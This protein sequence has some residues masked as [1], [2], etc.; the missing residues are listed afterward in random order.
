MATEAQI[1]ANRAN[2]GRSTGPKT[3]AGKAASRRNALVHGLAGEGVVL[4]DEMGRELDDRLAG[5]AEELRPAGRVEAFLVRAAAVESLKYDHATRHRF[6][7]LAHRVRHAEV[8]W[9]AAR[10]AGVEAIVTELDVA[11]TPARSS[12]ACGAPPRAAPG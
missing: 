6:A 10:R 9:D 12:A 3:E 2:A 11:S 7:A 1:A 4:P 8:D 5:W